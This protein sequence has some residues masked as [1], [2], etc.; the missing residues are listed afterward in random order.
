M[1]VLKCLLAILRGLNCLFYKYILLYCNRSLLR[2][3]CIPIAHLFPSLFSSGQQVRK[4]V[5]DGLIIRKPVTVHS[6]ARC[7]KN[8]LAR[9]KGRHMGVGEFSSR[10]KMATMQRW[11][12]SD[13]MGD[14]DRYLQESWHALL[15]PFPRLEKGYSQRSYAREVMLDAQHADPAPSAASL[16]GGQK[17]RQAHVGSWHR[18]FCSYWCG[19]SCF[20]NAHFVII[21]VL[22]KR[23]WNVRLFFIQAF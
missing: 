14:Y 7:R 8:T 17:D 9:R 23:F 13:Y 1:C 21:L 18:H 4:L 10:V 3:Q 11:S 19:L 6:R 2:A 20:S 12:E 16:Q 22:A 5:K 15:L